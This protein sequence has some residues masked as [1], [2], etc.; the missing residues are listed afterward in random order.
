MSLDVVTTMQRRARVA[1]IFG[2]MLISGGLVALGC[3]TR[4]SDC[5]LNLEC[6]SGGAGAGGASSSTTTNTGGSGGGGAPPGSCVPSENPDPVDDGCGVF[7]S[8]SLGKEGNSGAKMASVKAL[9]EAVTLAKTR[10]RRVYACAESFAEALVVTEGVTIYGG[11]DCT[12]GWAYVGETKKSLLNGPA[13]QIALVVMSEATTVE[14]VDFTITAASATTPGGS[15]IAA[16]VDHVALDLTRCDLVAGDGAEGV[17]GMPYASTGQAGEMGVNGG[18]ACSANSI[19][20]ADPVSRMCGATDSTSGNGGNGL[21]NSGGDG[22]DGLPV[23]AM[24]G[25]AGEGAMACTAG[26]KGSD[27]A[28]GDPGDGAMAPGAINKTGLTVPAG[29]DGM[30]G[31]VAQGGGGGGGAKG[32][33]AANKCPAGMAGGASGGSGGSGGCGGAG[34][35]GG[36]AGGSSIALISLDASLTFAGVTLTTGKGAKGG[37]GGLGQEGGQGG[38]PGAGGKVPMGAMLNL[39]C[40][41][42]PGGQGGKGGQGGGGLGGHAIGIAYAGA[43]APS[44]K[45]ATFTKGMPGDGGLGAGATGMGR[46]A[47]RPTCRRFREQGDQHERSGATHGINRQPGRRGQDR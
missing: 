15:S 43:A 24:N 40:S 26:T 31:A 37:A 27:G 44:I 1:A 29:G 38:P 17:A 13:D 8:S 33:V 28:P 11:L 2:L 45:G 41:G 18:D 25:G 39:A 14:V 19:I 46:R 3:G 32:G 36:S 6:G 10:G 22:S 20:G 9:G 21:T 47:Y 5:N 16:V 35:K 42:G 7:V 4:E 30:L 12:K 34:G 23:M